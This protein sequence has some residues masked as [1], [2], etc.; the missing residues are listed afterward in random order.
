MIA[1]KTVLK[2]RVISDWMEGSARRRF[3]RERMEGM[4]WM[5]IL[6]SSGGRVCQG[7]L[8]GVGLVGVDMVERRQM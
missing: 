4:W 2:D 3:R 6:F 1:G 5:I 7:D 8:R